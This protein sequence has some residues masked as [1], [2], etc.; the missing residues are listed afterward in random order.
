M[1]TPLTCA[2]PFELLSMIIAESERSDLPA[3]C[4]VSSVCDRVA[5]PL[6]WREVT[7]KDEVVALRT[8]KN[9]RWSLDDHLDGCAYARD[10]LSDPSLLRATRYLR[11]PPDP[12][13]TLLEVLFESFAFRRTEPTPSSFTLH[14]HF[15][16]GSDGEELLL[17]LGLLRPTRVLFHDC[18]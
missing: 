11:L 18:T 12:E 17:A 2:I 8:L 3:W 9:V 6:L 15:T 14:L 7:F 13:Y 5:R 4:L 10:Q 1:P 16:D